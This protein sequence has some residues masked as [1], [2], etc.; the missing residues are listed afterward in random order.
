MEKGVEKHE[1]DFDIYK[2]IQESKQLRFEL[3]EFKK[4]K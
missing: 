4:K 1:E 2:I 3:D